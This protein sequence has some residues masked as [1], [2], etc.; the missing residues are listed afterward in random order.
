MPDD[1]LIPA[2]LAGN[3]RRME[4]LEIPDRCWLV[5]GMTLAGLTA[6]EIKDR[7]GCSLRLVRSV[8]AMEFTMVCT[9]M[10]TEANNFADELRLAHGELKARDHQLDELRA[11]LERTKSKLNRMIDEKIVGVR[12][13][14]AGH[15]MDKYNT[16]V[17]EKTG[18]VF[19]RTCNR[20]K[21]QQFRDQSKLLKS[22]IPNLVLAAIPPN[23]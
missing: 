12:L 4:D 23:S 9:L 21:Q 7:L 20:D 2:V 15:A 3:S 18:K 19:C 11:E 8:R 14:S 6:D 1:Q 16:Y 5:A 10:Q 22:G 13:C 17:Q